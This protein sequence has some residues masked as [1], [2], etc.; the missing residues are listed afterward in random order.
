M[1]AD[2]FPRILLTLVATLPAAGWI[3]PARAE[4]PT[5]YCRHSG[6]DDATRPVP[7]SLVPAVNAAFGMQMPD[8]MATDTTVFRCA[9]QHVM[10]C[11]AGANLPCGKANVSRTPSAGSVQ[12]CHDNPDTAFIPAV[13]TGHDTIYAWRCRAGTAQIVRQT[14]HIDPRGFVAEF[15]KTLP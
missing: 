10:V 11:T 9:G 1:A 2:S 3:S 8:R 12:W 13:A 7:Q 5:Q 14:L 6:T 15:W 4:S